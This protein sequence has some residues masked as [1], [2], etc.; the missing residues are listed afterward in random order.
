MSLQILFIVSYPKGTLFS[1][2]MSRV[3]R[4]FLMILTS[5]ATVATVPKGLLP[6]RLIYGTAWKKDQTSEYVISAVNAGFRAI[7]TACQPKHYHELG[8]GNALS[9]LY[10]QNVISRKD[11]FLQT[12]FTSV[13]GQDPTKYCDQPSLPSLTH[14][15]LPFCSMATH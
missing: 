11:I 7:D 8:V 9:Y 4:L 13:H 5:S 3:L 10:Q 14:S 1:L 2:D 15:P 12:K 6:S